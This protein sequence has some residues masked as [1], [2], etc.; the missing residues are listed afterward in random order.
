[1]NGFRGI[2]AVI[3]AKGEATDIQGKPYV[4]PVYNG[5]GIAS[6][7]DGVVDNFSHVE[8]LWK[9]IWRGCFFI[10]TNIVSTL[11]WKKK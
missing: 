8:K 10:W 6:K 5:N 4:I 9:M 7:S 3:N 1:L 11:S 2:E